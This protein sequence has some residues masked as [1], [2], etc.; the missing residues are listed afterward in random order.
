[1]QRCRALCH[2]WLQVQQRTQCHGSG[3][4]G[5]SVYSD[6]SRQTRSAHQQMRNINAGNVN[7]C[8]P[9]SHLIHGVIVANMSGDQQGNISVAAASQQRHFTSSLNNPCPLHVMRPLALTDTTA[10]SQGLK[11]KKKKVSSGHFES[12]VF[13]RHHH[14]SCFS[15]PGCNITRKRGVQIGTSTILTS[16]PSSLGNVLFVKL[17][18]ER[19]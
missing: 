13:F 11:K 12:P 17:I 9:A 14:V 6:I 2:T 16:A 15:P 4:G 10:E 5:R 7:D 18:E 3:G 1:M 19:N 8:V